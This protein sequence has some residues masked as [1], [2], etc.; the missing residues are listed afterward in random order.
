MVKIVLN[1][2]GKGVLLVLCLC[3]SLVGMFRGVAEQEKK[4]DLIGELSLDRNKAADEV[5]LRTRQ[6]IEVDKVVLEYHKEHEVIITDSEEVSYSIKSHGF[7]ARPVDE[8]EKDKRVPKWSCSLDKAISSGAKWLKITGKVF[9]QEISDYTGMDPPQPLTI[10]KNAKIAW[11]E[12]ILDIF[13]E[14]GEM[15]ASSRERDVLTG[16]FKK[17]GNSEGL[18]YFVVPV[19]VIMP[20]SYKFSSLEFRNEK[21]EVLKPV[22]MIWIMT[23][24]KGD[25]IRTWQA[26]Y[27]FDLKDKSDEMLVSM[28][29]ARKRKEYAVPVDLTIDLSEKKE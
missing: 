19:R 5:T 20:Y 18:R 12:L 24:E 6:P 14:P 11:D 8:K 25:N 29:Y 2:A 21:E 10:Q 17:A 16:F 28:K 13:A 7:S 4:L 3:L 27:F 1:S 15:N 26:M 23:W 22:D 9:Y